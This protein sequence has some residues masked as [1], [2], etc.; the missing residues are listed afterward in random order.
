M[1]A[2]RL[3]VVIPVFNEAP[4]LPDLHRR[5]RAVLDALGASRGIEGDIIAVDDGSR[6]GSRE[7]L[8]GIAAG[9]PA[10]RV[11]RLD[12]NRGQHE[13]LIEGFARCDA[14]L[15]ISMDADLQNPPEE[16]PRIVDA[17]LEGNDLVATRRVNR[18]DPLS[19]RLA[20]RLANATTALLSRRFTM[21]PLH[22]V[23]CMLRGYSGGLI[24][25]IVRAASAPGARPPFVPA[26]ALRY[27]RS[28]RE[29]DV[30]HDRRSHG[31]SRYRWPGLLDIYF[32]LLSTLAARS[33][34]GSSDGGAPDTG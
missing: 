32:R 34:D 19:R 21:V 5:L 9:D 20:A 25:L 1:S 31:R 10:L 8:E 33:R 13:A 18:R 11:I 29:V 24:R 7:I 23:G 6:D 28:V 2:V 30:G 16:I 22:D 14:P 17:L 26:L 27:A 12:R 3:S 15:V 4:A